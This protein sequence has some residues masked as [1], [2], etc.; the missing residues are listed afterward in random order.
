LIALAEERPVRI[1]REDCHVPLLGVE[2]FDFDENDENIERVREAPLLFV[3]KAM[4]CWFADERLLGNY[5]RTHP[6]QQAP[7]PEEVRT[8]E[9]SQEAILVTEG[10]DRN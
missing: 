8:Q 7:N 4:L 10:R 2:D 3:E 6:V 5:L 1:K 9:H